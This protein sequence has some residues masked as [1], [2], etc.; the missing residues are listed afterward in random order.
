M[1]KLILA[2]TAATCTVVVSAQDLGHKAGPQTAPIAIINASVHPVSSPSL[3]RGFVYFKD[4]RIVEVGEGDRVF[5]EGTRVIDASGMQVWPG[6]IAP[7]TELGLAEIQAVRQSRDFN[8]VG[9]LTP[10]AQA[11][12]ATNPDSTLI[13]VTRSNG[14]LTYGAFPTAGAVPGTASV[15]RTDGWTSDSMA[16]LPDAGVIVNWPSMRPS[17]DWWA[18]EPEAEQLERIR[19]RLGMID[20]FFQQ[21][22]SYR[23]GARPVTDLRF[24]AALISLPG[25][26]GSDPLRPTFINANDVDQINAAV[27]WAVGMGMR[28]VIVGGRDAMLCAELLAAHDVPVILGGTQRFPKRADM[29]HDDPYTL[30]Q[31]LTEAGVRWCM[32]SS[33]R[34]AH[35]RNLPYNAAKSVAFGLSIDEAMRGLTLS[36]AEILEVGDEIGSLDAGKAATLIIADGNPLEVTTETVAAFIDGRQIDVGNKQTVLA[37]KYRAKYRQTGMIS[38]DK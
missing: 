2:I 37:E 38:G 21:A 17:Q 13:P 14:I 34:T 20:T 26:D 1:K 11:A 29:P 23:D 15:M 12:V 32:A 28:P 25:A 35:E 10:E 9:E 33:D 31:R 8:E 19:D 24:E 7:V 30:P 3:G 6:L 18:D 5:P 22:V 16:L 36:T 27:V 4:G